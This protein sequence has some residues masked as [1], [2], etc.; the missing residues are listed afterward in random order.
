MGLTDSRAER[1]A[2][3][4]RAVRTWTGE[5]IDLG[6][7]NTLLYYRDLRQGTLDIGPASPASD[8]AVD[9]L[10]SSRTM[11]LSTLF[12]ET[13][14]GSA[15]RRARAV[16]AKATENFEERGLQTMFLAWGMATWTNTRGATAPAAPVLLR[17][18]ALT[19]RG[20][21]E[22]DFDVSLPGE[23][24]VNPTLLHLLRTDF[25]IELDG[26]EVLGL[27][28]QDQEP[29]SAAPVF[30][31]LSKA[32]SAM[33][34]FSV[35]SRMVLGNFSYAKLPMVLDLQTATDLLVSS[36]LICAIAGDE[37]ARDAIRA[38]HPNLTPAE[39]DRTP[40]ADEFLVLDADASQ[41]Y[42][43]N[44]A[45]AG[46]DLVIDGPPGT[47]KSQTIANL[48]AS[49]S[50]RGKRVLFVAEKRAAIDAVLDRLHRVGLA[51]L[52]LDLHD[53]A[54]PKRKL[55]ADLARTLAATASIAK[56]DMTAAQ[57]DLVRNR[58]V[59]VD[60][61]D[62]LHTPREPWGVSVYD[63]F[64]QLAG[65]PATVSSQQ[66]VTGQALTGLDAVAIRQ[67]RAD[68]EEFAGLGGLAISP[69]GT[70]WA[71]AFAA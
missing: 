44:S 57:E 32:C 60:R 39:P 64:A 48:I 31:R 9:Q 25:E 47:G 18:A 29:P 70:P 37:Q 67:A 38:R 20:G 66:R 71:A 45:V 15:A 40:P 10:L 19:A 62:A 14:I 5:L 4:D 53:G 12:G 55:A 24:E 63:I 61:T 22:E 1:W 42:A 28:D 54:G 34:G 35:E 36:D 33:A 41:S 21:T 51:D 27:L 7:R 49:L 26:A 69:A 2:L 68:L 50:A 13:S 11:R 59:L 43:V 8:V 52:V 6:G 3:I 65:I 58:N 23:W 46:A 30:E 56:P 17:P 16:K